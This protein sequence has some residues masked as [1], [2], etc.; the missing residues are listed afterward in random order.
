MQFAVTFLKV[1]R[2]INK[3]S[4]FSNKPNKQQQQKNHFHCTIYH[5]KFGKSTKFHKNSLQTD[6]N[7]EP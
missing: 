6:K 4:Y 1:S 5:A 7:K 2:N 3:F